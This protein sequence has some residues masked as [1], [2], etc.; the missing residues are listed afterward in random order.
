[1]FSTLTDPA[2][3]CVPWNPMGIG[4][5][6]LLAKQYLLGTAHADQ[7]TRQTVYAVSIT[8]EPFSSWAGPVSLA[9]SSEYRKEEAAVQSDP[10][11]QQSLWRSGNLQPLD[12]GYHVMEAAVETLVPLASDLPLVEEWNLS[13]AFRATDYEISGMVGTWKI[14][15]TYAPIPDVRFRATLSRDIRAPN[16][17]ELFQAHN[18]GLTATYDPETNTTPTHGRTQRGNLGLK[19][20]KA[21]SVTVGVVLQPSFAPGL[22]LSVDYWEVDLRD[23]ITLI[24]GSQLINLCYQGRT[25]FC[26]K[27]T[28]VNGVITTVEQGN[29]NFASQRVS[30][31]DIAANYGFPLS[32]LIE[33]CKGDVAIRIAGT[34]YIENITEDGI[35]PPDDSVGTIGGAPETILKTSL[36]YVVGKLSATLT[37]R[38]FT[39]V[40]PDNDYIEC[41]A[42]CPASTVYQRTFDRLGS[43]GATYLD[44]SVSYGIRGLF[45]PGEARIFLNVRNLFN[46]DP[47]LTPQIGTSGLGYIYSRSQ[48]GRWDKLGRLF[49]AGVTYRF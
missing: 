40:V 24:G 12:A 39:D 16:I 19:P 18:F 48:N 15:T 38:T 30:G 26:S 29:Y 23:A 5:N 11:A 41:T 2:N 3:G 37:A 21:D 32:S 25:D 1:M 8:G 9:L 27:I 49:R 4:V 45:G 10:I 47:E 33:R 36:G 13:A 42:G 44:A 31:V 7:A 46:K 20:E 22:S 35:T 34:H 43:K 6:D 28:R 17:S 14:G